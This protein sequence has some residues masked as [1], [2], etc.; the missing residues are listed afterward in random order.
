MSRER[1]FCEREVLNRV[2]ALFAEH[3]YKGTSLS[4]LLEATGLGKQSLYNCFGDKRALYLR[5]LDAAAARYAGLRDRMREAPTGRAGLAVYFDQLV[6]GCA[7]EEPEWRHC[8]VAGGLLEHLDDP[9][10]R[11]RLGESWGGAHELL[12]EQVERGQ[13][14]G[15]IPSPLPSA[16]LADLLLGVAAGLRV[17]AGARF[18]PERLRRTVDL[19]F[20]TLDA[21]ELSTSS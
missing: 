8:I 5:A 3:G 12:R 6:S 21:R 13:R 2:T 4:M 7:G 19:A 11:A 9:L 17:N 16:E 15:S 1:Q 14:D 10:L 20:A 18:A